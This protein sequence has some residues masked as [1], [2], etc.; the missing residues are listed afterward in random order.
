MKVT[1]TKQF[2]KIVHHSPHK[3]FIVCKPTNTSPP[4]LAISVCQS[5][6]VCRCVCPNNFPLHAKQ[7]FFFSLSR[8]LQ[9]YAIKLSGLWAPLVLVSPFISY[10]VFV[11]VKVPQSRRALL[12][13]TND[14]L[15]FDVIQN[16]GTILVGLKNV[17]TLQNQLN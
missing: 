1:W 9:K 10:L 4:T 17:A 12:I 14:C 11:M 3:H 13:H 8:F 2:L 7:T 6:S 5:P 15:L 16:A